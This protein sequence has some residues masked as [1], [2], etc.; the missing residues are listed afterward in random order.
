[1]RMR[2]KRD[3]WDCACEYRDEFTLPFFSLF[4]SPSRAQSTLSRWHSPG[5]ANGDAAVIATDDDLVDRWQIECHPSQTR[6]VG[7]QV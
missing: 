1:M 7:A 2:N 5:S 4:P 3:K 6:P